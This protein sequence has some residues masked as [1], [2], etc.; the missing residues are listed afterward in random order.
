MLSFGTKPDSDH[1]RDGSDGCRDPFAVRVRAALHLA[2]A[3]GRR[4]DCGG[5]LFAETE[6]CLEVK[7]MAVKLV[8]VRAPRFLSGFLRLF[9][10]KHR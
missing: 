10:K 6:R 8:C 3:F 4:A 1:C 2:G 5:L 9:L 7:E